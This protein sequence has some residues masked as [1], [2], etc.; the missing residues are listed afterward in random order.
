M[1]MLLVFYS[2]SP[3]LRQS[4]QRCSFLS[5]L[6]GSVYLVLCWGL[7]SIW[8]WVLCGV[9]HLF[10]FFYMLPIWSALSVENACCFLFDFIPEFKSILYL[11]IGKVRETIDFYYYPICW[12]QSL[13][14]CA[15]GFLCSPSFDILVWHHLLFV[16]SPTS[17]KTRFVDKYC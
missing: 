14:C 1:S 5:L 12:L 7:P 15:V 4:V 8:N 6:L 11:F 3:F 13:Y 9:I 2:E 17:Y 10:R 16:F